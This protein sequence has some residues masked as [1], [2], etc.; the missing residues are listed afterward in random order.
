LNS[1]KAIVNSGCRESETAK[2]WNECWKQSNCPLERNMLIAF[3]VDIFQTETCLGKFCGYIPQNYACC[4]LK[5]YENVN[6]SPVG[7]Y[8]LNC[9][10]VVGTILAVLIGVGLVISQIVLVA[11][12]ITYIVLRNRFKS[13][14]GEY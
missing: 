2:R 6:W 9:G 14:Y 4:N 5:S 11:L 3:F 12:L 7:A 1:C 13:N 10:N 8:S